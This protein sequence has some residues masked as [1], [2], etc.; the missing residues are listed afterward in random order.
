MAM[1]AWS[2]KVWSSA[3]CVAEKGRASLAAGDGDR[4]DWVA[5]PQHRHGQKVRECA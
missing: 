1:T 4:P 3:I 2:A 5:L